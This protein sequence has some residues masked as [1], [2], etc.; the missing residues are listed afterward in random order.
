VNLHSILVRSPI[1]GVAARVVSQRNAAT[2]DAPMTR[3]EICAI[4]DRLRRKHSLLKMVLAIKTK[5]QHANLRY[6]YGKKLP[7]FRQRKEPRAFTEYIRIGNEMQ[8]LLDELHEMR[9][10][11]RFVAAAEREAKVLL[12][13]RQSNG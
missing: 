7:Q 12:A 4:L 13:Q 11:R 10:L 2:E 8:R 9:K 6:K 5:A 3:E 1:D